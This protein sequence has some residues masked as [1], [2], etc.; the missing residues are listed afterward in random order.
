MKKRLLCMTLGVVMVLSVLLSGCSNSN[1]EDDEIEP[2][3]VE[4]AQTVTMWV[5]TDERTTEEAMN[6]VEEAFT[7]ITK[8]K[9]KINVDIQFYTE[10]EYYQALEES[11]NMSVEEQELYEKVQRA[12]RQ[13]I[14][15]A[16]AQGITD[17][18]AITNQFYKDHPEY[19]RFRDWGSDEEEETGE[20]EEV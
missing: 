17:E 12:L 1:G 2:A 11:I 8:S 15:D 19:E 6:A 14:R 13:A 18:V 3:E 16:Q 4:G 9:Y 7:K 5:I 10:D 20:V